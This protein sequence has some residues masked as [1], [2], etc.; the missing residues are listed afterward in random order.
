VIEQQV[1]ELRHRE[2]EHEI[3]DSSNQVARCSS[4]VRCGSDQVRSPP[5]HNHHRRMRG[6]S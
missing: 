2:H 3:E 6:R 5:D 4:P 1:A